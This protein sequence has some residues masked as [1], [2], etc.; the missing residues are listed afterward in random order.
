MFNSTTTVQEALKIA[1]ERE[2]SAYE[3]YKKASEIVK[4]PGA[5][6]MFSFLAEE[7]VK[8]IK[9]LEDEYDKNILQEM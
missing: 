3:F 2:K 1:I 8:H 5:R 4:D 9:M 6:N 7:E